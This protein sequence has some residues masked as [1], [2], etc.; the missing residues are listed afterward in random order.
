MIGELVSVPPYA[1]KFFALIGVIVVAG[2][3]DSVM[4]DFV[5]DK[6]VW[7]V[8]FR[9]LVLIFLIFRVVFLVFLRTDV[10]QPYCDRFSVV[11]GVLFPLILIGIVFNGS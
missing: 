2:S 8:F 9:V 1:I 7:S 11:K 4:N 6:V 3:L 5:Y 10:F